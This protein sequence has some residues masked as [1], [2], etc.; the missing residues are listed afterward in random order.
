M[1]PGGCGIEVGVK[2]MVDDL[3][4][5]GSEAVP[6]LFQVK[7]FVKAGEGPRCLDD[8]EVIDLLMQRVQSNFEPL[9]L[10]IYHE[11][12]IDLSFCLLCIGRR[13]VRFPFVL[14]AEFLR[15]LLRDVG[16]CLAINMAQL[17]FPGTKR[18]QNFMVMLLR[19]MGV[20]Q[21]DTRKER[22]EEEEDASTTTLGD[23]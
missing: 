7:G 14:R 22:S 2:D 11:Q 23:E 9:Q 20:V 4:V 10:V 6:V 21:S 17:C 12:V 8:D 19:Q 3:F 16:I 18:G 1:V 13:E 5:E 15:C